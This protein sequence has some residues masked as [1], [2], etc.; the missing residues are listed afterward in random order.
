MYEPTV[1]QKLQFGES[2][3]GDVHPAGDLVVQCGGD[4]VNVAQAHVADHV[5]VEEWHSVVTHG[6]PHDM[7]DQSRRNVSRSPVKLLVFVAKYEAA[8]SP[9]Q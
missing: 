8:E 4:T 9:E 1:R 6:V 5:L 7:P 2:C 3:L